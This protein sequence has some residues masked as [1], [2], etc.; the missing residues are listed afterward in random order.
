M[1]NGNDTPIYRWLS[2]L[3]ILTALSG[4][5]SK[6]PIDQVEL[7]PAPQVYGDGLINPLPEEAPFDR[8]PYDGI[9]Y[10]TDRMPAGE[11]DKEKY[12][13][14]DRGRILR[15]GAAEVELG[16]KQFSWALARE[17]SMLSSRTEKYPV[18]IA[19]AEEWGVISSSVPFWVD[20]AEETDGN[21]PPD[22]SGRFAAAIDAQM[23]QSGRKDVYIFVHGYKVVF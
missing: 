6:L 21:P 1:K 9:L 2:V 18:R 11:G 15:V 10:A 4:C 3:V 16:D 13:L 8:I 20:L 5:A 7:M 23:Q 17:I 19:D 22:A 14:N 12:Y